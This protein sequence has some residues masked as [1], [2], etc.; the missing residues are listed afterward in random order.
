MKSPG[1]GLCEAAKQEALQSQ[2]ALKSH[3]E[4]DFT[5][6]PTRGFVKPQVMGFIKPPCKMLYETPLPQAKKNATQGIYSSFFIGI[7]G[8]RGVD[9]SVNYILVYCLLL[10]L[11]HIENLFSVS[12]VDYWL[13]QIN[14]SVVVWSSPLPRMYHCVAAGAVSPFTNIT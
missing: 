12:Y 8:Y 10:Y 11:L 6:H 2:G 7:Y 13:S 5:K 1:K 9:S 3:Q 14:M 4:R